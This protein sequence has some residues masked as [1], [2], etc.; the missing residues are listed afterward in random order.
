VNCRQFEEQIT[1]AVDQYLQG[2]DRK[3]FYDHAFRCPQCRR[4]FER[5]RFVKSLVQKHLRIVQTPRE[6][7]HAIVAETGSTDPD[8]LLH[9]FH[10]PSS[11]SHRAARYALAAAAVVV[12]GFLVVSRP[13]PESSPLSAHRADVIARSASMYAGLL[14]GWMK[15]QITSAEPE[16]LEAFFAGKTGF[17]VHVHTLRDYTPVG[18]LLNEA[19][20]VPLAHLVYTFNGNTV[21]IYQTCWYT[22]QDG[23]KLKIPDQ[24][25]KTLRAGHP[26]IDESLDGRTFILWTEGKTLCGAIARMDQQDLLSYLPLTEASL[27][28]AP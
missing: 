17:P 23:R 5:E 16:V 6:I 28:G 12:F 7:S 22:V 19:S 20:G 4:A 26:Y 11:R 15:P 18:A 1:S 14:A 25:M 21:Y 27:S 13:S 24:V 2:D 8:V 3:E 9:N 10:P